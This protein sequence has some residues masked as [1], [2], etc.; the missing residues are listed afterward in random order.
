M[1][2][3]NII[4]VIKIKKIFKRIWAYLLIIVM[5]SNTTNVFAGKEENVNNTELP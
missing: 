1:I 2:I 3:C 5:F 4:R